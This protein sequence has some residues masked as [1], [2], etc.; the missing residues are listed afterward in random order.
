MMIT[1]G[2][3]IFVLIGMIVFMLTSCIH[4][5]FDEP[6]IKNIPEGKI[7]TIEELRQIYYDSVR[8]IGKEFYRFTDDYSVFAIVSMD[9]LSGNIYRSI[10]IQDHTHA[11]SLRLTSPGGLYLGDSVRLYLKGTVIGS[12]REMIQLDSVNTEKNIIKQATN[13]LVEPEI[14][15]IQQILNGGFQAKLIKL[16]DVQFAEKELGKTYADNIN[17]LAMSHDLENCIGQKLIVRTSGHAYFAGDKLP[18]GRGSLIAIASQYNDVWQ[19]LIRSTDEVLLTKTRCGMQDEVFSENFDDVQHD[20][21]VNLPGWKNIV[22]EG[23]VKWMGFV[24]TVFNAAYISGNNDNNITWLIT[25]GINI[26]QNAGMSFKSRA[27]NIQGAELQILISSDYDGGDNPQNVEWTELNSNIAYSSSGFS[28]W[29]SSGNIDL[30][31]YSGNVNIAFRY[32]AGQGKTGNYFINN[33][34]IYYD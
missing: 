8:N 17:K 9:E 27:G 23:G 25:P 19:L 11:I 18:E 30:N 2:F 33:L 13:K 26:Q 3:K 15:T 34:I 12:Y 32:S 20:Q 14:V 16:E 21:D 31:Q 22:Q 28:Q 29:V 10:Y 7:L 4:D 24:S 1:K 6:P 5:D